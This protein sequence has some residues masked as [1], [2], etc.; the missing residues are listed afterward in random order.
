M[1]DPDPDPSAGISFASFSGPAPSSTEPASRRRGRPL[2]MDSATVL[3]AIRRLS[4]RR[5]GLFRIHRTHG[6]LYSRA[7]RHFGSWAMAV[8]AAGV[9]YERTVLEARTRSLRA[10]RRGRR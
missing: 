4:R 9:D 2:E 1:K 10:R 8:R 7:R 3:E 6:A 5:D